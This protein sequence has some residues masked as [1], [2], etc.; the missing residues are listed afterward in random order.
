[1]MYG[2]SFGPG[3]VLMWL[4]MVLFWVFVIAAVVWLVLALGRSQARPADGSSSSSARRILEER[5]A[6]GEIDAEEFRL[7]R[8]AIE[9][10][11]K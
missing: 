3:G 8:S 10:S 5:L 6:R 9:E 2:Y 4:V 7:R 11:A 1:M